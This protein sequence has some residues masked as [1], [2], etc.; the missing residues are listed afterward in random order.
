LQLVKTIRVLHVLNHFLPNKTAGTEVYTWALC[1]QLQLQGVDV[2]IV[3]PH[4][5]EKESASYDFDGLFV[6]KYGEPSV[7]DRSLIMGFREPDG[8]IHFE[9]YIC[10]ERQD[11]IH[12][13]ELAGSNGIT[14]KHVHAA[15]LS[16]AKVLMTFHLAGYSCKTGTLVQLGKI[17]CD[18]VIDLQKCSKCYLHSTGNGKIATT[19]TAASKFFHKFSINTTLWQNKVG[20]ALG[21]V[22]IISKLK[23]DLNYLVSQCDYV[24]SLTHWY[25]KILIANGVNQSKIKVIKQ[26][27]PFEPINNISSK[28]IYEGP[29]KLIFLGRINKFKGLHLLIEAIRNID[30]LSI[31]LSI[32]GNSDDALYESS[33]RAET[34]TNKNISWKGKLDQKKV[35][36]T[37]QEHD[38]LCLCSTFSEMSPL[39]IQESFAAGI[40]V[41]AS[42]VYGNAEQ[43]SHNH[44]GLLFEFNNV[45]DLQEQII[46]CIDEPS[47]LQDLTKNIKP[48]RSFKEVGNEYFC[49]YKSLLN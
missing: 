20:T 25:E 1:K 43:I 35:V 24:V 32:F 7:V 49:L 4:Y 44:N 31:Q 42:N 16:G 36:N 18:G 45:N 38:A 28:K 39:V 2:K 34:A 10:D 3:I 15:K 11:I 12:F 17:T 19:L 5:D 48:P 9:K 6:H 14:L 33:L 29:L 41:I 46:R 47:L 22:S 37:L 30:P 27:L 8:L 23:E 40:P 26:G 13:H 21:T